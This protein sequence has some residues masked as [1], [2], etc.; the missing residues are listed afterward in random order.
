MWQEVSAWHKW[1]VTGAA[2]T[3]SALHKPA[4]IWSANNRANLRQRQSAS[5][6]H[7]NRTSYRGRARASQVSGLLPHKE[8]KKL[9]SFKNYIYTYIYI[10]TRV[11]VW[12]TCVLKNTHEQYLI[13][14]LSRIQLCMRKGRGDTLHGSY[15]FLTNSLKEEKQ[16]NKSHL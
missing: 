2:V 11:C 1:L 8:G 9:T 3:K 15:K 5:I 7:C 16:Y 13:S 10:Y 14:L 6:W 12:C 4:T